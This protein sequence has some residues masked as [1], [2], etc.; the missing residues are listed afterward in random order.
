M[1][2]LNTA[3]QKRKISATIATQH[4]DNASAPSWGASPFIST[5]D[6]VEECY[7]VFSELGCDEYMWD[8]EGKFVDEAVIDRL[9]NLYPD[10]FS[11]HQIG[12]DKLLTFRIP[13][14]SQ[15]SGFRLARSYMT[16]I[17]AAHTAHEHKVH[18][19]P[20]FEAILP[21]TSSVEQL[22]SVHRKYLKALQFEKAIFDKALMNP[23]DLEVIPLIEGTASLIQS[24]QILKDYLVAYEDIFG[25]KPSY[26]RPFIARSDPA[27]D[28]GY[29]AAVLSARGA[30]SEYYRF[31]EETHIPVYPM[32]GVGS[33]SF[34]GGLSPLTI[35]RFLK[36]YAGIRT[37]TIQ[38]AFRYDYPAEIV[39]QA[40]QKL[41]T[42]L[43]QLKA[44]IFNKNEILE[45]TELDHFFSSFYRPVIMDLSE[46]IRE[47]A[48]FIP[49][50]RERIQHTGHFGYSRKMGNKTALPR[51]IT[52]SAIFYSLGVP[53]ALIGTGRALRAL[54]KSKKKSFEALIKKYFPTLEEDLV[55]MGAYMNW[56]N[57]KLL[58]KQNSAWK[59]VQED[60]LWIEE[61]LGKRVVPEKPEEFIHRNLTSNIY[62]MWQQSKKSQIDIKEVKA[63]V[64]RA[65]KVRRSIG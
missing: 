39:K 49:T 30:I 43:P 8:W 64:L 22:I 50:H 48:K 27:L 65:A 42:K 57:I 4:P 55:E 51:A 56:E 17:T 44:K 16:L 38:S 40:I 45:I 14:I 3:R 12:R 21:M 33:L 35:D 25:F 59:Y 54:K 1:S 29:L 36:N 7:R 5:H 10:Y 46:T 9:F 24:R 58:M 60:I 18:F 53:P 26:L 31:Q 41:N 52:F 62:Q 63:E 47:F 15:E 34:R 11:K 32:I 37:V 61:F 20:I 23:T 2:K 19:P 28:A 13:N 6:E